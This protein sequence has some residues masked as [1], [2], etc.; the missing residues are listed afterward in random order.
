MRQARYDFGTYGI[1][2][3]RHDDRYCCGLLLYRAGSGRAIGYDNVHAESDEFRRQRRHSSVVPINSFHWLDARCE[4]VLVAPAAST[5]TMALVLMCAWHGARSLLWG[6]PESTRNFGLTRA[7]LALGREDASKAEAA[8][9]H[10]K[11]N[12]IQPCATF[13]D[14]ASPAAPCLPGAGLSIHELLLCN[15]QIRN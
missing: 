5:G 3:R 10:A 12:S 7:T 14:T 13:C 11:L 15:T 2:D 4:A 8:S 1:A 6:T 9:S